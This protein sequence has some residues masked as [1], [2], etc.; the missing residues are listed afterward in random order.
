MA[1]RVTS[2]AISRYRER[3]EPVS[4]DE[5]MARLSTARIRLMIAFGAREIILQSGHHAV[6]E[7]G[8]IVTVRPKPRKKRR[9][10]DWGE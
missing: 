9:H 10:T 7:S 1:L 4:Y 8:V 5:A 6:V 3:V 2:H